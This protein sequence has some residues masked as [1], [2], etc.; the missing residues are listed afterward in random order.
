MVDSTRVSNQQLNLDFDDKASLEA[1]LLELQD[2]IEDL[3]EAN[4]NLTQ[5]IEQMEST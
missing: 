2:Q 4:T 1:L 5:R 3:K